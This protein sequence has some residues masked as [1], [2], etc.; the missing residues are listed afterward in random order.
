[1]GDT[2]S[3]VKKNGYAINHMSFKGKELKQ[4]LVLVATVRVT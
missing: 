3:D 4:T 2:N 1:M